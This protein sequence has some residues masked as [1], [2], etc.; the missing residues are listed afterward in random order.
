[1][2]TLPGL[3][4]GRE[5]ESNMKQSPAD[6]KVLERMAPGVLC[7]D[8][9]LGGDARS[10]G[11]IIAADAAAIEDLGLTHGRVADRLKG[12]LDAAMSRQGAPVA[13]GEGLT[14]V[15]RESMGRIPSPWPGEGVFPKGE[16]ELTWTPPDGPARTLRFT[17]LSVHL[18]RRHG[19]YQGCGSRYRLELPDLAAALFRE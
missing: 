12:I 11:E 2:G 1:M 17:P 16:V 3:L 15:Y 8:G 6:A 14:A 10:P 5:G 9:F 7:R 13:A 19:F 18:I 4:R